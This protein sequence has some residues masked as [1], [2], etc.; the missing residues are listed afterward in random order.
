MLSS[1]GIRW[2]FEMR[3]TMFCCHLRG[4]YLSSV[5]QD[6]ITFN[7]SQQ[8]D[9]CGSIQWLHYKACGSS[10]HHFCCSSTCTE[11]EWR[12]WSLYVINI[13][14]LCPGRGPITLII[15]HNISLCH[16][17]LLHFQENFHQ[18]D[19][20]TGSFSLS[21]SVHF[22]TSGC[23]SRLSCLFCAPPQWP[24]RVGRGGPGWRTEIWFLLSL[25][26]IVVLQFL[27]M[28]LLEEQH[29]KQIPL[30]FSKVLRSSVG[31]MWNPLQ[32]LRECGFLWCLSISQI[33]S[34]KLSWPAFSSDISVL[35]AE[36]KP[37]WGILIVISDLKWSVVD[38]K[39]LKPRSL[40]A[41]GERRKTG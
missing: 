11:C 23:Y 36:T 14:N 34:L 25:H 10:T 19:L 6:V 40:Q 17:L 1:G 39:R 32:H 38:A 21:L 22:S 37:L 29:L 3:P 26:L 35:C 18:A 7:Y 31:L 20:R 5:T 2:A 24:K 16:L 27:A 41:W 28:W 12:L 13:K 30:S 33:F 15:K 4:S 9:W 8:R